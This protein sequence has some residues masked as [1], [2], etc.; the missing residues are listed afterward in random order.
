[1]SLRERLLRALCRFEEVACGDAR[2][3]WYPG[4]AQKPGGWVSGCQ[5][6][7]VGAPQGQ[8]EWWVGEGAERYR[9]GCG[10]AE[11]TVGNHM[12]I[13]LAGYSRSLA[14]L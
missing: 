3:V 1:M 4:V 13:L 9:I 2:S 14:Y 6:R 7:K 12:F 8:W 5:G 11:V 10:M